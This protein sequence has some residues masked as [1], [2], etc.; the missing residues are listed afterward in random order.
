MGDTQS[1]NYE[2]AQVAA[3]P[4]AEELQS[5][6]DEVLAAEQRLADAVTELQR[7]KQAVTLAEAEVTRS[8]AIL[9]IRRKM[10]TRADILNPN[11]LHDTA[12]LYTYCMQL[13]YSFVVRAGTVWVAGSPSQ[14]LMDS[15]IPYDQFK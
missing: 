14:Q 13:G 10:P 11:V 3:L 5:N 9:M 6:H 1:D 15:G 4:T 7:L 8:Q 12:K 2:W